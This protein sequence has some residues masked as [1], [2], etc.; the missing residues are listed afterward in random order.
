MGD[1]AVMSHGRLR[2]I[3]G[4]H[5]GV[6]GA[7]KTFTS[8]NVWDIFMVTK[9]R[10]VDLEVPAGH[11]TLVFVRRGSLKVGGRGI[12]GP[13]GMVRLDPARSVLRLEAL[14]QDTQLLL[15]GGSPLREPIAHSGPFVMN[16]EAELTQA[17][18][19]YRTGRMGK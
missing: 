12:V 17:N 2:I 9:D 5:M 19:D 10:T 18:V 8:M 13:Q 7:A 1:D 3:A 6:Q 14:E 11:T 15:L 16:T 4:M